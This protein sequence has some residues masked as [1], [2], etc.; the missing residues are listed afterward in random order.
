MRECEAAWPKAARATRAHGL[1][2][3]RR[4]A[5]PGIPAC[6]GMTIDTVLASRAKIR[7]TFSAFA[8]PPAR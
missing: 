4:L 1:S 3:H 7:I 2:L 6:A 8:A 5:A